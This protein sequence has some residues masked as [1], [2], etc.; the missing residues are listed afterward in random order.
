MSGQGR[1]DSILEVIRRHPPLHPN[2]G[3]FDG[4]FNTAR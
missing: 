2:L 3:I 1:T 4:F